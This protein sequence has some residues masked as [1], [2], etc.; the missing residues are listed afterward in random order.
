MLQSPKEINTNPTIINAGLDNG[1][2]NKVISLLFHKAAASSALSIY[3][4]VT[5]QDGPCCQQ[6]LTAG[7]MFQHSHSR[8]IQQTPT[9]PAMQA[10]SYLRVH[11]KRWD[12][13]CGMATLITCRSLCA[14]PARGRDASTRNLSNSSR[15]TPLGPTM[16]TMHRQ[17]SPNIEGATA[18]YAGLQ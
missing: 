5:T 14:V 3:N 13:I 11:L 6:P 1:A 8:I 16:S 2:N 17:L 18:L 15:P 9:L 10:A 12:L 4:Q 7:T